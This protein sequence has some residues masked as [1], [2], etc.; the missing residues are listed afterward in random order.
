MIAV[1]TGIVK[2]CS[3]KVEVRLYDGDRCVAVEEIPKRMLSG[4]FEMRNGEPVNG[5]YGRVVLGGLPE[6]YGSPFYVDGIKVS[7]LL[8]DEVFR[9]DR[10]RVPDDPHTSLEVELNVKFG[11]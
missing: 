8:G 10:M 2:D 5:S 6:K 4:A 1:S 7:A 3:E 11:K 9:F